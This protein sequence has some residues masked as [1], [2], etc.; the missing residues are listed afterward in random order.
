M[1]YSIRNAQFL[2]LIPLHIDRVHVEPKIIFFFQ[3]HK[4]H[5]SSVDHWCVT[6]LRFVS[7]KATNPNA[8]DRYSSIDLMFCIKSNILFKFILCSRPSFSST[9]RQVDRRPHYTIRYVPFL[10]YPIHL[11]WL[12]DY[13]WKIV[14]QLSGQ[15][16][17][18][19]NCRLHKTGFLGLACFT[20]LKNKKYYKNNSCSK[21]SKYDFR[22]TSF[23]F[24]QTNVFVC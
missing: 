1:H 13:R 4:M 3:L 9:S 21:I 2:L 22:K 5:S 11:L 6:D 15:T 16:S 10:F 8:I 17:N 24:I 7:M 18:L 19:M 20:L 14:S 23:T 12:V